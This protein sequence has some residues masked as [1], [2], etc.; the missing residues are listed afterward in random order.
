MIHSQLELTA[1]LGNNNRLK[2]AYAWEGFRYNKDFKNVQGVMGAIEIGVMFKFD[3]N[4]E[5][6]YPPQTVK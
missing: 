2:I 6:R 4:P 5:V 3:S 1:P